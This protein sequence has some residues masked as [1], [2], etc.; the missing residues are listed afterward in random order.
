MR[1]LWTLTRRELGAF[2]LSPLAYVII[3]L[4]LF[5][6]GYAF[7]TWLHAGQQMG[8]VEGIDVGQ[9]LGGFLGGGFVWWFL[10][11]LPPV[12][13]FRSLAAEK[14]SGRIEM[15]FTAPVTDI[16]VVLA[17]FLGALIF[18]SILWLSTG[19]YVLYVIN[20]GAEPDWG[21]V[22]T[23]YLGIILF[24]AMLIAIN[25]FFSSVTSNVVV[26]L[27]LSLFFN[28]GVVFAPALIDFLTSNAAVKN[29]AEYIQVVDH[30]EKDFS[31]GIVD[32]RHIIYYGSSI[33]LGLFLTLR[34]VEI[35]KW[36]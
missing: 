6:Q 19:V 5:F 29:I 25:L 11:L 32:T 27:I 7:K 28:I 14:S 10:M 13:T 1:N 8:G 33:L 3:F 12:L 26:A 31:N 17:K 15:L 34:T 4:F 21:V 16:E 22:T 24:G 2:F 30:L 20:A 36:R 23:G 9:V 35:R 18:Y